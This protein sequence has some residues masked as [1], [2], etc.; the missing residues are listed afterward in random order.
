MVWYQCLLLWL[1]FD[2]IA[3]TVIWC[4]ARILQRWFPDWW[5]AYICETLPPEDFD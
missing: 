5:K 1:A 3:L 2:I 4:A